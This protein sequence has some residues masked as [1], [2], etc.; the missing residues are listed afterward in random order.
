MRNILLGVV[1]A[2]VFLLQGEL[3]SQELTVTA[4]YD[5]VLIGKKFEVRYEIQ[6]ADDRHSVEWKPDAYRENRDIELID[7]G[8]EES[9]EHFLLRL[10]LAVFDTGRIELPQIYAVLNTD[11]LVDTLYS[12]AFFIEVFPPG[13][14]RP[15]LQPIR[16]IIKD[17]E[18]QLW[19][20]YILAAGLIVLGILLILFFDRIRKTRAGKSGGERERPIDPNERAISG[21][22]TLKNKRLIEKGQIDSF[23]TEL[24]FIFRRW[25]RDRFGINAMEQTA[26]E[27]VESLRYIE[28]PEDKI[29][30]WAGILST[31][32]GVKYAK[33]RPDPEFHDQSFDAVLQFIREQMERDSELKKDDK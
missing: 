10:N 23:H 22:K 18:E 19:W 13:D 31:I 21:L 4:D 26:G 29:L 16:P 7:L 33:G 5:S 9:G 1:L 32:D 25:L 3:F 14:F 30:E 8:E 17:P 24:S 28:V 27:L 11:G 6:R 15:E 12:P 20:P 2:V